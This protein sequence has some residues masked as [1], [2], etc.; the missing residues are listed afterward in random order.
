MAEK[1]VVDLG[2]RQDPQRVELSPEEEAQRAADEEATASARAA[3]V[4][5]ARFH[6]LREELLTELAAGG[7]PDA[8]LRAE[9]QELR[10]RLASRSEE[11]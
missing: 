4:D 7:G 1:V 3:Q 5:L 2:E 11:K 9:F 8:A 10:A 6:E